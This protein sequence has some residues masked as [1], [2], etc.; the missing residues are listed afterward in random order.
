MSN[1]IR[2]RDTPPLATNGHK[3]SRNVSTRLGGQV[4]GKSQAV[5]KFSIKCGYVMLSRTLRIMTCENMH[6]TV[7][8]MTLGTHFQGQV[9]FSSISVGK[10]PHRNVCIV[11]AC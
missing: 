1:R 11:L 3:R 2:I 8:A 10:Y 7:L 9:K 5:C 6:G 4:A